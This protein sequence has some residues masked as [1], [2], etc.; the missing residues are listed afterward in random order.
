MREQLPGERIVT[1]LQNV[2]A[3]YWHAAGESQPH[4]HAVKISD[5]VVCVFN[6]TP[7][8]KYE[9]YRLHLSRWGRTDE[10]G[11]DPT[12]TI[13][14]LI[15]SLLRFLEINRYS[16]HNGTQPKFLVD[17]MP[18]VYGRNS[19]A[20]LSRM[21]LRN[22][23]T[24]EALDS[25]LR[26]VEERGCVYLPKVNAFYVREFQMAYVAEEAA[27]FLHYACRGRWRMEAKITP[28]QKTVFTP[29][30]WNMRLDIWD[31]VFCIPPGLRLKGMRV[32]NFHVPLV[33][34]MRNRV[35]IWVLRSVKL[36]PSGLDMCWVTR[37]MNLI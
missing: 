24:A 36:W 16:T 14:N 20:R 11:P 6:S 2:D 31:R 29:K 3:L 17:L 8:E 18:E 37:C 35:L 15:D 1:V 21:L 32:V 27:R 5:D 4:V 28:L 13:Y 12:P 9:N 25:F 19:E 23:L 26:T 30:F 22:G 10:E 7:L 34:V 33:N